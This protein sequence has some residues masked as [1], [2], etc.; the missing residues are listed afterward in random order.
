MA[1]FSPALQAM[2]YMELIKIDLAVASERTPVFG[3]QLT[4]MY[5]LVEGIAKENKDAT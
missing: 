3:S 1:Q 2:A 5:A 4:K